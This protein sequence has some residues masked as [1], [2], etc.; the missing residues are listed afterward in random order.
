MSELC[1]C[2]NMRHKRKPRHVF[3]S[4]IVIWNWIVS[5]IYTILSFLVKYAKIDSNYLKM[6]GFSFRNVRYPR[7]QDTDLLQL[8]YHHENMDVYKLWPSFVDDNE[9]DD[10]IIIGNTPTCLTV[11]HGVVIINQVHFAQEVDWALIIH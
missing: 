7:Y 3:Y 11:Y 6:S 4:F 8:W 10:T 1:T 5:Y 9:C 2:H